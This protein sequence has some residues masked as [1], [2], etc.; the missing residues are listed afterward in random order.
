MTEANTGRWVPE[1]SALGY[2]RPRLTRPDA[3]AWT[4]AEGVLALGLVFAV[5]TQISALYHAPIGSL[6][7]IALLPLWMRTAANHRWMLPLGILLAL[8]ALSGVA[9]TLLNAGDHA[10]STYSIIERSLMLVCLVG[11][12]GALLY[13]LSRFRASTVAMVY[14]LGMAAAVPLAGVNMVNPWKFSFSMPVTVVV[15]AWLMRSDRAGL[16]V[17]ATLALGVVGMVSDSRSYASM[18]FLAAAILAWNRV[19]PRLVKVRR[20]WGNVLGLAALGVALFY[21]MQFALLQGYFGEVT[22]QRT[23]EQVERSGSLLLG[24]RPELAASVALLRHDPAGL[25]SGTIANSEDVYRAQVGMDGI[26]YDPNNGYVLN[27]MFGSGIE[28]HS[29]LADFWLWFGLAGLAAAVL[30]AMIVTNGVNLALRSGAI[31][32]LL[33][34]VAIRFFWDLAFS[35][36]S[37]S[38]RLAVLAI[39]LCAVARVR[40]DASSESTASPPG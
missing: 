21:F 6:L 37:T 34:Y 24:G 33:A 8:S 3:S 16:Q 18:M 40:T 9:L 23:A 28:V 12:V 30:L 2:P 31:T 17:L 19:L 36:A 5:G 4:R 38:M 26:G 10:T 27:Y 35:P 13:A 32:A 1:G 39:A 15:L 11:G 25:G 20:R 14:G 7:S 22:Q 29:L